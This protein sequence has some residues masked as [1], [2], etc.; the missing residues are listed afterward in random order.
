MKS[1]LFISAIEWAENSMGAVRLRRIIRALLKKG[2]TIYCI[3]PGAGTAPDL[4][5]PNLHVCAFPFTRSISADDRPWNKLKF[6]L[7][8]PISA[9]AVSA[10]WIARHRVRRVFCSIPGIESL[11]I[12]AVLK[13][14]L[15]RAIHLTMEIRDPFSR[16]LIFE[17][18]N[19]KGRLRRQLENFLT[20]RPDSAIFLTDAIEQIY[21]EHF[22]KQSKWINHA[23]VITNGFD[24][25]EFRGFS[26]HPSDR[27]RVTHIGSFYGSR[28]PMQF[29]R[30]L[31]D[32]VH[33]VK[34]LPPVEICFVGRTLGNA[35]AGEIR[36]QIEACGLETIVRL[37]D[38]VSHREALQLMFESDVNLLITHTSG[39]DYAIPGKLFEYMGA[40]RPIL[41]VTSDRL[42]TTLIQQH[43]LGWVCSTNDD[44]RNWFTSYL[45]K[46]SRNI[47]LNVD[48]A[49]TIPYQ[50]DSLMRRMEEFLEFD[51][52]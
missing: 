32:Y 17:Q 25:E 8:F 52:T 13:T 49:E 38:E 29:L 31:A 43:R 2:W 5:D 1:I 10:Y 12:G 9:F 51:Q 48:P 3:S 24:P 23:T 16:N 44:L 15:G 26:R 35:L 40:G 27:L 36:N 7:L 14:L 20:R 19:L 34:T 4:T 18:R 22:G 42:V 39:S 50:T 28:N 45:G 33:E 21:L 47:A 41:A 37:R 30:V 11:A 46:D 6:R